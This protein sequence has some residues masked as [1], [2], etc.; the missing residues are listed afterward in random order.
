MTSSKALLG[1]LPCQHFVVWQPNRQPA[2]LDVLRCTGLDQHTGPMLDA[3]SDDDLV[4]DPV[5]LLGNFPDDRVLQVESAMFLKNIS[6]ERSATKA[7][8]HDGRAAATNFRLQTQHIN[9]P[10]MCAS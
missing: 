5:V 10:D 4:G 9:Q 7:G 1:Q 2:H 3:P 6:T 8:L